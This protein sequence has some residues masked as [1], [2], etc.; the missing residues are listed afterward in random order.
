MDLYYISLLALIQGFTEF[1]P[2]SSSAHLMVLSKMSSQEG[3]NLQIDV[4]VHFGT[5]LA[6]VIF[7]HKDVFTLLLGAKENL[8][9]N[10]YTQNARFFR[11]LLIST[12]PIFSI[13]FILIITNLIEVI[14]SVKIIGWSMVVFA[15]FLYVSDKYGKSM[16]KKYDWTIKDALFL[17]IW[18]SIALIPGASRSG[19]TI[20]GARFLGFSRV[21]STSIAMLMA[22]PTMLG[23]T[24]ILA[25]DLLNNNYALY[26]VRNM[27]YATFFSFIVAIIT[28]FL[29]FRYVKKLS[30]TPFV[31]YRLFLGFVLLYISY[32]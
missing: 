27:I 18:Q 23:S 7:F 31:I 17:G 10:L 14:R 25:A 32:N 8:T 29:F 6:L 19:T 2:V 22:I 4:S 24:S 5:L 11:L 30:F 9:G 12:V 26:E 3:H 1:L 13:G 21:D 20:T 15:L 28:L 16:R